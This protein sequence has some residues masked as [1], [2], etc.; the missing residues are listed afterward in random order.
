MCAGAAH[1]SLLSGTGAFT[2]S[3]INPVPP[4]SPPTRM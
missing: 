3:R 1:A 4:V 2:F